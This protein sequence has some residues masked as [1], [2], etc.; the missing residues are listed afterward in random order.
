MCEDVQRARRFHNARCADMLNAKRTCEGG[1]TP[2]LVEVSQSVARS[3]D[4]AY[5]TGLICRPSLYL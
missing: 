3:Y 2:F 1:T 4:T 5:P